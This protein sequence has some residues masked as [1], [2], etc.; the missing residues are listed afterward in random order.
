MFGHRTNA[1]KRQDEKI[2]KEQKTAKKKEREAQA[3]MSESEK[4][5]R[6]KKVAA[7]KRK[8]AKEKAREKDKVISERWKLGGK[9]LEVVEEYKYLGI[10]M[11]KTSGRWNSV[12]NRKLASVEEK[13]RLVARSGF[14]SGRAKARVC[15]KVWKAMIRPIF[16]YGLEMIFCPQNTMRKIE[17]AQHRMAC[18]ILGLSTE[19]TSQTFARNEL[20]LEPVKLRQESLQLRWWWRLATA[21][22][23]RLLYKVWRQRCMDVRNMGNG[24]R[25]DSTGK[26]SACV[27]LREVM[28][29][30]GFEDEWN[31]PTLAEAITQGEW[32][33][34]VAEAMKKREEEETEKGVKSCAERGWM[35]EEHARKV[36]QGAK[37][38]KP[39][40]DCANRSKGTW[41]KTKLRSN[42]LEL[43]DVIGEQHKPQWPP[44]LRTCWL[45]HKEVED[46]A[47]F[48]SKCDAYKDEREK[49]IETV[50]ERLTNE[51]GREGERVMN[52]IQWNDANELANII[53]ST[54]AT[55][56]KD[57]ATA[58][59]ID[60]A[61]MNY[62]AKIW[63]IR[64]DRLGGETKIKEG[65]LYI[66]NEKK[67][68]EKEKEKKEKEK[69]EMNE[70]RRRKR[71]RNK[72]RQKK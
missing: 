5:E 62:I 54:S 64:C 27:K 30:N 12:L 3:N 50:K 36:M 60:R 65:Q 70:N 57:K 56:L 7:E 17:T 29:K 38:F 20:G 33:K 53:L 37:M 49:Y 11:G 41:L 55:E 35:S 39:Y 31:D 32:M 24:D 61:S 4:R 58:A 18:R 1:Q 16:E 6:K 40:L 19:F 21:N 68:K 8:Q 67:E 23:D 25:R 9:A 34:R 13:I 71:K 52:E 66:E 43:F 48:V 69:N 45:C 44:Q 72:K 46:T 22:K 28:V 10:E 14:K 15:V 59:T 42:K 26:M 2:R 51:C 63:K 47:H